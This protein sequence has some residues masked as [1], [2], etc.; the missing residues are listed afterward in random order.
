MA[1]GSSSLLVLE[2]GLLTTVQD[3]G[4]PGLM[5]FGVSPGGAL[6]RAALVLGNRLVGNGPGAAALEVTL[7]GPRLRFSAPAVVAVTGADLG[8]RLGGE[9]LPLWTPV[10]LAAGDELAFALPSGGGRGTRAYLCLAGG[11]AVPPVMGSRS[12]DLFGGFGGWEGR[13]L[14]AGDELPVGAP[15]APPAV[16][17]RRRLAG[18]PPPNEPDAP[19]RVVLGPQTERFTREGVE[20][21]LGHAYAVSSASDRMGMRLTGPP[22]ALA[23]GADLISEGIAHGAVQVP[24][25]GQPIVL[26]AA[27]QTVGGYPKIA[28]AIGADLD[29]LG[30]R[31][32]GDRVR[33][34]AVEPAAARALTLA[35]RARLGDDAVTTTPGAWSGWAPPDGGV[36]TAGD[37]WE[38]WGT[39]V[40][41]DLVPAL[42]EAGVTSLRVEYDDGAVRFAL[43]LRRD[44]TGGFARSPS[45]GGDVEPL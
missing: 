37:A 6:D 1:D 4:R 24:G 45:A 31:R 9:P 17:L 18:P 42:R 26:L 43:E 5:R 2:P 12:T 23:R 25:D 10:A 15:A 20:T 44:A 8:A 28:T 34:A 13:A 16:L 39:E 35:Y 32:P 38:A 11:F 7:V 41:A 30:Q 40:V 21:F 14:R 33:F 27:R 3:L 19:T 29:A 36:G 22:I